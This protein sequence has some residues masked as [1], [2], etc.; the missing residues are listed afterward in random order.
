MYN[1][2]RNTGALLGVTIEPSG[3][4]SVKLDRTYL[5]NDKGQVYGIDETA[6]DPVSHAQVT[7]HVVAIV[8]FDSVS[9]SIYPFHVQNALGQPSL[10]VYHP[11][12]GV[13]V[14][15]RKTTNHL[16][17]K[18]RYDG[19]GR[20]R[21]ET[22]PDGATFDRTFTTIFVEGG[23]TGIAVDTQAG[24]G[25][26]VRPV[27]DQNGNELFV[28]RRDENGGENRTLSRY[29]AYGR[30]SMRWR[31]YP[32]TAIGTEN[33]LPHATYTYDILGRL[34]TQNLFP[35][36]KDCTYT[37]NQTDCRTRTTVNWQDNGL[38]IDNT[39]AR[40]ESLVDQAG[41][42]LERREWVGAQTEP[43]T[44]AHPVVT[45]YVYGPFGVLRDVL[46]VVGT[47]LGWT[48]NEYDSRGR[49]LTINDP[50]SGLET[51]TL[52]A[53]D[54]VRRIDSPETSI[55]FDYDDLDRK[56]SEL[57]SKDGSNPSRF[58]WDLSAKGIGQIGSHTSADGITVAFDYDTQGRASGETWTVPGAG[59]ERRFD[60]GYDSFG[61]TQTLTYPEVDGARYGIAFGY[62]TQSGELQ[63]VT[64]ADGTATLWQADS[65]NPERNLLLHETFGDGATTTRGYEPQ[66]GYLASIAS[67]KGSQ[68]F[69]NLGFHLRRRGLHE[70]PRK[71]HRRR[72]GV[73][74]PRRTRASEAWEGQSGGWSVDYQYDGIGNLFLRTSTHPGS[75]PAVRP[76]TQVGPRDQL[77]AVTSVTTTGAPDESYAYDSSGRQTS[78]PDRVVAYTDF[79]LPRSI[80]KAG[81]TSLFKYD[82]SHRR[83]V[84]QEASGTTFYFGGLYELRTTLGQPAKHVMY[85]PGESGMIAQAIQVEG[86]G[87]QIL[88]YLH[89]D[90]QESSVNAI[91][92]SDGGDLA[93]MRFDPFGARIGTSNPPMSVSPCFARHR[94]HAGFT[95]RT[96]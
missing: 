70:L 33:G 49:R 87:T 4:E 19:F 32:T 55:A 67:A 28:D 80:T 62:T 2:D 63:K 79:D 34:L 36:A 11:G 46:P 68:T 14:V 13:L 52:D 48:H 81:A 65:R 27:F 42:L 72:G 93:Q 85:I 17:L 9:R 5:R 84:K 71:L 69:Q 8:D 15:R 50:D 59:G 53:F 1:P 12:L 58:A 66:R 73:F 35:S 92:K 47:A 82:A 83:A 18:R 30:L 20:L 40:D 56:T 25:V 3:G 22:D 76:S 61:R 54:R 64:T 74:H 77:Y 23:F 44:V 91:T 24:G 37:G 78:G 94:C 39:S 96:G 86:T 6:T 38:D 21:G 29:D 26:D 89:G 43:Q 57:T 90:H 10:L 88:E 45:R 7:R 95:A 41:R 16:L 31:P 51:D 75:S 60:M